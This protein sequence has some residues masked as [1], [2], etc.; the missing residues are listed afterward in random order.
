MGWSYAILSFVWW[1][2]A[3]L[4]WKLL[5]H[6]PPAEILAQRIVW[7]FLFLLPLFIRKGF[8]SEA[9]RVLSSG[10]ER[11]LVLRAALLIGICWG[12]YIIAMVTDRVI[13]ASLGYFMS[14]IFFIALGVFLMA[15]RLN[16]RQRFAVGLAIIAVLILWV[17]VG[18][19]PWIAVTLAITFSLYGFT[20]KCSRLGAS[21]S[22]AVETL[23][24]GIPSTIYLCLKGGSH[25]WYTW[26]LLIASGPVTLLPQ[27]WF[28]MAARQITLS[29]VGFLH[30]LAPSLN[31]LLGVLVFHE[32]FGPIKLLTF[33]L[34]WLGLAVYTADSWHKHRSAVKLLH[35]QSA[36]KTR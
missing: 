25:D 19:I 32:P 33:G 28:T 4:F 35:D 20:K 31:F 22:V 13:E 23:I 27:V 9:G 17:R 6:V 1:G 11:S 30:Y 24:L 16:P 5:V 10:R 14:P 36:Q 12:T 8:R 3:P 29:N 18:S 21:S 26:G 7:S 15:E 34:I 2:L